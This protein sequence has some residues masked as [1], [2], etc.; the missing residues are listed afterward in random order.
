M[1]TQLVVIQPTSFCNIDCQYCYLPGRAI[2]RRMQPETLEQAFK[3]LFASPFLADEVLILWHAGE[4]LVLPT[5][6][7]E[8]AFQL[9]QK[10][11]HKQIQVSNAIQTNATLITQRWCQF[12]QDHH[13]HVGVSLDGTREMNDARRVDRA[14]RGTFE[15]AM[16]GIELLQANNIAFSVI[17]VITELSVQ[18]PDQFWQFFAGLR[19]YSLGLN[20]EEAE[21]VNITSSLHTE[22]GIRDY[23][24]FIQRLLALNEQS[25]DPLVIREINHLLD[26]I[27]ASELSVHAQTNVPMA[28]LNFDCDG[29]FS[30][31]SPELLGISHPLY[32][33]FHFGNVFEHELTTIY[34]HPTF[35]RV[36]QEIQEGVRQC[37]RTCPYFKICGGG[38]PSNKLHENGTFA[39]TE[40]MNCRLQIQ[41]PT[42]ALLEHLERKYQ[43]P[44]PPDT[45]V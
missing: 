11:N 18:Q 41:V 44:S 37:A 15:R 5:G 33:N 36:W 38:S 23:K 29:N 43:L 17:S 40:T 25:P 14:K 42:D 22:E 19:P 16:R 20:P 45:E 30:T 4:P 35:R 27:Q 12:F 21:G 7:Y 26:L 24:R 28:I 34:T 10:W 39:S 2:A 3:V 9:Q 32:G 6:F 13:I 8:R 31:F 1:H